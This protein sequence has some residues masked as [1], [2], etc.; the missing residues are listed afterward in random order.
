VIPREQLAALDLS[1]W[2]GT[3]KAAAQHLH[4]NQSTVSRQLRAVL[5]SLDLR[6]V[7]RNGQ[8]R[9][10]GDLELLAAERWVHQLA[11][12][13]GKAPLRVEGTYA[14]GP[15]FLEQPLEGWMHGTFLLPGRDLPL[16]LLRE[17]VIDAWLAS[18]QP[19]LPDPDDPQWWVLDLVREPV[20]LLAAPDHP[21]AG[22]RRPSAD[23]LR[24]F[25][26]L[27][28]PPG[29]FPRTEAILRGQGLWQQE[30]PMSRY[31]PA[32]WEG[33]CGDGVT[34]TYGQ[35]L[36]EA[37]QPGTVRLD[38]DLGLI[39]GEALVVRRDLIDWPPIQKRAAERRRRARAVAGRFADVEAMN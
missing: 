8:R 21:L 11:R 10:V 34:L 33:R 32:D 39:S 24:R 28:L 23:D 16:E 17:R 7:R 22:V 19:D 2:L 20:R 35:S 29:W 6:L 5:H 3:G 4:T 12:L 30:V 36:T 26:S 14:S 9:L 25:P 13:K 1:L 37:L 38:W 31:D 15:W 18:Y 27:A